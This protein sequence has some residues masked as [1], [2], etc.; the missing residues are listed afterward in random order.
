MSDKQ[1]DIVF[2]GDVVIGHALA[3]VKQRMAALFK[4]DTAKV[5]AL[6]S[7]G[8]S[9]LK[10]NLDEPTAKK[11]QAVLLKAGA[12]VT[13]EVAGSAQAKQA[14]LAQREAERQKR[15]AARKA[16]QTTP[17]VSETPVKKAK[18]LAERLQEQAT[19]D[20]SAGAS[21][22]AAVFSSRDPSAPAVPKAAE[23]ESWS[24]NTSSVASASSLGSAGAGSAD[25]TESMGEQSHNDSRPPMPEVEEIDAAPPP[26]ISA[27]QPDLTVA[28]AE[29]EL[30]QPHERA[31]V[32][33]VT[34]DVSNLSVREASGEL[35]DPT[36]KPVIDVDIDWQSIDFDVAE[37]GSDLLLDS[38]RAETIVTQVDIS[39]LSVAPQSGFLVSEDERPQVE[40]VNVDI[41]G[42]SVAP[43]GADLEPLK[44]TVSAVSP[45]ISHLSL[46]G[47]SMY[48]G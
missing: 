15:L 12:Q 44:S 3:D 29:G 7:G 30:L 6:F 21:A 16:Q 19:V 5:D 38:E 25:C 47:E 18:T 39:N 4:T 14:Q 31:K 1:Y 27:E 13:V 33:V 42:I 11:Y 40:T 20:A 34:V 22:K 23:D 41:S 17:A 35:L 9:V 8:L 48:N 43:V 36:E 32:D 45:D 28:E 2:R 46:K 24:P 26:L 37:V 10:R